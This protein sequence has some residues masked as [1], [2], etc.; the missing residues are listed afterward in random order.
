LCLQ[1]VTE[2]R[3]RSRW[4]MEKTGYE[5]VKRERSIEQMFKLFM[6]TT[7]RMKL[8][9]MEEQLLQGLDFRRHLRSYLMCFMTRDEGELTNCDEF[10][11]RFVYTTA[12]PTESRANETRWTVMS[13]DKD[14]ILHCF[15][16][17]MAYGTQWK[18]KK[19]S[20]YSCRGYSCRGTW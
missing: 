13:P 2:K 17:I 5:M 11:V 7:F 4:S 10:M 1:V 12:T 18:T 3:K 15:Q 14:Y 9:S 16:K 19:C 20:G 8:L 6:Y